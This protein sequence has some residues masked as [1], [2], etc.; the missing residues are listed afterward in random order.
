MTG[1]LQE[2]FVAAEIG[3]RFRS[4]SLAG[5]PGFFRCGP[6]ALCYGRSSAG[7]TSASLAE[8]LADVASLV[9]HDG[10]GVIQLPFDPAEVIDNLRLERYCASSGRSPLKSAVAQLYYLARP[11]LPVTIR[12]HIQRLH[13]ASARSLSFPRW[14]VDTTADDL[15]E[16]LMRT[17]LEFTGVARIPFVWFWP[18][19]FSSC[20]IVTH[21][22]ETEAGR[23]FCPRLM[24]LNDRFEVKTSFQVVPEQRYQV[25]PAFLDSI[26]SRG[27]EVNVHDLNHDGRLFGSRE[28]FRERVARINAYGRE[29]AATGFRSA[30][31]YRNQDWFGELEFQYDM[32]VPNV[33]HLD[34][35]RGGCCTVMPYFVGSLVELPVTATQDYM[36]FHI[37]NQYS[38]ELW[39]R[40]IDIISARHGLI[41]FIVHPDYLGEA[42]AQSTYEALLA[43]L[44]DMRAREGLW[45]ALPAQVAAWWRQRQS[46]TLVRRNGAWKIEGAG[47]DRARLAYA[48]L[49][50]GRLVYT[51]E[52]P[53]QRIAPAVARP[54]GEAA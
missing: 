17:A 50:N 25:T 26:R 9:E 38:M 24:D 44:T 19:G 35:Q 11:L 8:A 45:L 33:A 47:S 6:H 30:V 28:L 23:A 22:V 3:C 43:R 18:D 32:S 54:K 13:A 40:Q 20:A 2:R 36:L 27:F 48:S 53:T 12:K 15:L 41:S 14:P 29:F 37:L 7:V 34:P 51:V 42:R 49:E 5:E 31:L 39:N 1:V 16:F 46:L 52:N 10:D 4:G 21:D